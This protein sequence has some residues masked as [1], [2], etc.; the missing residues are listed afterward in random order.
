MSANEVLDFLTALVELYDANATVQ[1]ITGRTD[2]NLVPWKSAL[3]DKESE[4]ELPIATYLVLPFPRRRGRFGER[5]G[6]VQ[7]N[8]WID[9]TVHDLALAW[10]LANEF[11]TTFTGVNLATKSVDCA[12]SPIDALQESDLQIGENIRSVR[13]TLQFD[14]TVVN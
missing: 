11:E 1:T 3:F 6:Q 12:V 9:Q 10:S 4:T 8:A 5:L 7:F 2:S 13:N 14:L